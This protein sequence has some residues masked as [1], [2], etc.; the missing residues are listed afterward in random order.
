[1]KTCALVGASEFNSDVFLE[2]DSNGMFD[3]VIAVDGGLAH[4]NAIDRKAD[5]AIGDFDSLGYVPRGM[6]VAQFKCDKDKSDMELALDRAK[7]MRYE[8][9]I[10]FG[11]LGGRLDHTIANMQVFAGFSERGLKVS[12]VGDK[13]SLFFITGPDIFEAPASDT[14]EVSVFAMNDTCEGV[15]ERGMKWDLDDFTMTNRTSIGLSNTLIGEPV[16]IGVEKGTIV[17]IYPL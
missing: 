4:L 5:L 12:A 15:F 8:S 6:R 3:Y 9:A 14:G 16:M 11:G 13:E 1:M 7:S 10:V 2:M 17:I